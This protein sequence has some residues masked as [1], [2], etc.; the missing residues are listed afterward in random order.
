MSKLIN[1]ILIMWFIFSFPAIAIITAERII[2]KRVI[3][4]VNICTEQ[5]SKRQVNNDI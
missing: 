1:F 4:F 5:H 2:N 3:K